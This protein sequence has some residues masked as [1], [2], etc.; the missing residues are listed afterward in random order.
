M[1]AI[2]ELHDDKYQ[3]L[4]DLT[5]EQNK[6]KYAQLHG[7]KYFCRTNNFHEGSL[8]GYQKMW[9][10]KDLMAE[11]PEVEWFWWTGTDTMVMNFGTRIE[12]RVDN[13]RH[14]MICVDVNGINA[15]SF[16]IRNTFEGRKFL[17]A[18]LAAEE[19]C[20]KH[21]DGEQRAVAVVLG[22]PVTGQYVN[23]AI[24]QFQV[25][26]EWKDIVK[27]LPQRYM[28]SFNYQLYHY[29]DHRD[30]LG[31][32]GNWQLGD[33]LI[34]WPAVNLEGRIQLYNFYKDYVIR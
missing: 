13:N 2:V 5:W 30:S 26:N 24:S 29:K 27:I 9:F 1:Y 20:S 7:Y 8:I 6:V 14:F 16:L 12:D 33:W 28:N 10:L 15:D 17:D 18:I 34:H 22:L 19:E 11:H 25:R 21:W 4:A 23:T 31:W 32:D 3:P